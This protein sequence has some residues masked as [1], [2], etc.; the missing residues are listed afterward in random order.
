MGARLVAEARWSA[1]MPGRRWMVLALMALLLP[2]CVRTVANVVTLPVR[3]ASQGIDWA[4]TSQD[5]ADRNRGR[6][7]RKAEARERREERRRL[8]EERR[9]A[10]RDRR[11]NGPRS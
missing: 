2:G 10:E 9:A 7:E 3:A 4:T 5:E 6:R 8:K 11:D 1:V